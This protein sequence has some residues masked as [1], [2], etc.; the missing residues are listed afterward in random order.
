[1]HIVNYLLGQIALLNP[2][3]AFFFLY[4]AFAL[5]AKNLFTKALK[6]NVY[7]ILLFGLLFS[8][9]GPV[10]ANWTVAAYI[11]I[12]VL[13]YPAIEERINLHKAVYILSGISIVIIIVLRVYLVFPFTSGKSELT[14]QQE[15]HGWDVWAQ[16][17][18]KIAGERPV[19]FTS[20]YQLPSKYIYYARK[21]AF[22]FN[23]IRYRKNQFDLN[24][25]EIRLMDKKVLFVNSNPMIILNDEIK[26]PLPRLDS[27]RIMGSWWYYTSIEQYR[28]YNFIPI[29]VDLK[30]SEFPAS[31]SIEIP[32]ELINPLDKALTLQ[33]Q[34]GNTWL[35]V[36]FLQN[37]TVINYQE[38]QDISN[39]EI[40]KSYKTVLHIKAPEKPGKYK[41]WVSIRS[42]WFP[43]GLNSRLKKVEVTD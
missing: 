7:G 35:A 31:S 37:G 15:F 36:S 30:A 14:L 43:P 18:E 22:T 10:E 5:P 16:E 13:A 23:Y 38:V 11:P 20:S 32:V 3:V 27:A 12:I 28:S 26:Y 19:V 1:M 25:T 24:K 39:L 40:D 29:E 4:F 34:E 6:Y 17:V 9:F 33:Q 21:D 41:L 2:L 42:G 8:F